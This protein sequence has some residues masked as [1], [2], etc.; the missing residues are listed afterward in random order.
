[1]S[2][3]VPPIVLLKSQVSVVLLYVIVAVPSVPKSAVNPA[4]F[5]AAASAAPLATV[6]FKSS[7][8]SVV[9]LIVVVVPLTVKSPVTITFAPNVVS[10][11]IFA[12]YAV[13]KSVWLKLSPGTNLLLAL[14]HIR[15]C[16]SVGAVVVVSTSAKSSILTREIAL[17]KSP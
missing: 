6:I 8:S 5:A 16:P 7:T 14:S 12:A 2:L 11:A 17:S 3:I 9:V 15:D 1:M 4:P 13:S 10:A